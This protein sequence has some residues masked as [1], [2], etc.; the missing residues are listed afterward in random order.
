MTNEQGM[1]FGVA[2]MLAVTGAR[3]ADTPPAADT[4]RVLVGTVKHRFMVSDHSGGGADG[5]GT[6]IRIFAPDGGVEWELPSAPDTQDASVLPNGHVLFCARGQ[7]TEVDREKQVIFQFKPEGAPRYLTAAQRLPNGNTL[8]GVNPDNRLL[9]VAPDGRVVKDVPLSARAAGDYESLRI[10]RQLTNGN[11]LVAHNRKQMVIEYDAAGKELA[12]F[13]TP[14]GPYQAIRLANGHTVVS[15]GAGK[16]VVELDATGKT[17]WQLTSA[18]LPD[19]MQLSW[20]AGLQRL[21]NGNL[22]LAC[23]FPRAN[24]KGRTTPQLLEVSRDKQVVWAF[25][26]GQ[27]VGSASNVQVLD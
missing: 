26:C 22:V 9:E 12:A 10:A 19:G 14:G 7:V 1:V 8:V 24:L 6:K 13:P 3:A 17:V 20:M 4:N 5:T 11:Y 15:C 16:T 23:W 18:D 2:L 21:A 25:G 27:L